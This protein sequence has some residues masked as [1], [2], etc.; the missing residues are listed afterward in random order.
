[1]TLDEN[2]FDLYSTD[3]TDGTFNWF[4]TNE[5]DEDNM[6]FVQTDKC[7]TSMDMIMWSTGDEIINAID[8]QT[9]QP[10][11]ID[12]KVQK[13]VLPDWRFDLDWYQ[14]WLENFPVDLRKEVD[15]Y[16]Y[17]EY[18][19]LINFDPSEIKSKVQELTFSDWSFDFITYEE[20]LKTFPP[21]L[22]EKIRNYVLK[23][24]KQFFYDNED[25]IGG[26]I[27]MEGRYDYSDQDEPRF[28]RNDV[29]HPNRGHRERGRPSYNE[30]DYPLAA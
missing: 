4:P 24:Y 3:G 12:A 25:E 9:F 29:H 19:E 8:F 28:S 11:K 2:K 14:D 15:D 27:P 5:D 23:E 17:R 21:K 10:W 26:V 20:W 16:V 30:L 7:E 18:P 1:M 22:Q 6:E 13:L